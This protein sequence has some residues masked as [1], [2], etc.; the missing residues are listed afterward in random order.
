[1]DDNNPSFSTPVGMG[2]G[3]ADV[4][5]S[6]P[7]Q[8]QQQQ[9]QPA[10]QQQ[11][12]AKPSPQQASI[13]HDTLFGR[14]A[15]MLLGGNEPQYSVDANGNTVATQGQQAPG[16]FFK[17]VLAAAVLGGA[18][19]A[20]GNPA[21]GIAGGLVRGGAAG[22]QQQQLRDQQKRA[23]AQED[24]QNQQKVG[25]QSREAMLTNAQVQNMHSEMVARD[26]R[27][28]LEDQD[29]HDK[30]NA[31]SAALAG[32]L[33][34]AGG[35][36]AI[37][38]VN[39]EAKSSFTA[40]D[41][42]AAYV[43]DPSILKG[44]QGFVRHFI[45][46]TDSSELDFNGKNWVDASG[47]PVNMSDKTTVKAIDVPIDAMKT[48]VTTKGSAINA[49]YGGSLVDPGKEYQMSPL[50]M[51]SLN[52]RRLK[53]SRDQAAVDQDAHRIKHDDA[54]LSLQQQEF[55]F[56][57]QQAQLAQSGALHSPDGAGG[58]TPDP[59]K[60]ADAIHDG[61]GTL[62]Q[63]TQGMGKDASAFRKEVTASFLRKYPESLEE[64]KAYAKQ[65][66]NPSVTNQISTARSLFGANGQPGALD[67]IE[68]AM[69]AVPKSRIPMLTQLGQN[70]AY[71][72]GSPQM[73]LVKKLSTDL[74]VEL[75]KFN[76][77]GGNVTSDHQ[78]DLYREQLATGD[79]TP[80]TIE[81]VLKGVRQIS[82]QRLS[83]MNGRN[84]YLKNL[85]SDINDPSTGKPRA[86]AASPQ[87]GQPDQPPTGAVSTGK[88]SDGKTYYLDA[89]HQPI[90]PVQ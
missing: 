79:L 86:A 18:A 4:G 57:K 10:P 9:A 45:D 84:P 77:G 63:L 88:G 33:V 66:E 1:M 46:T 21:Q 20:N 81:P 29:A 80:E 51:D 40:P 6:A 70:T 59:E 44:P 52:A 14:A 12:A 43:K 75:A 42:A 64:Y 32:T 58:I 36:P 82:S 2:G 50:D 39:G 72:L 65:A 15:K 83:G 89:N 49:A 62:E 69:R 38:P 19:G 61:R 13:A 68:D 47:D 53:E 5:S 87:N 71:Q 73:A 54:E 90:G 76:T 8:V 41:L 27:S 26:R 37:I 3:T 24:F 60:F 23:Q 16:S 22:I 30:H 11:Q 7:P 34:A 67:T 25:Q 56:K 35:T 28:D 74:A 48:K 78:L 31:A 55:S 17:N 85:T